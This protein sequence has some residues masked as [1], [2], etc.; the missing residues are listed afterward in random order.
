MKSI[1]IV[2]G[3]CLV[4]FAC[5]PGSVDGVLGDSSLEARDG[6][7]RDKAAADDEGGAEP[8]VE[9][10]WTIL[11]YLAADN[12][13][14]SGAEFTLSELEAATAGVER[15]GSIVALVDRF[16]VE[17]TEVLEIRG[18]ERRLIA[19]FDEQDTSDP[20]VLEE[21]VASAMQAYPNQR[22][23]LVI[24]SEGFGWRGIGRDN[25]QAEGAA[26]GLMTYE[27]IATALAG[28]QI[29]LLVL[30]GN[31][32]AM[33]EAAYELRDAAGFLVATQTKIQPD[34]FPYRM[35]VEDLL[36][37]P[38]LASP[39]ALAIALV[40][41]HIEYYGEQGNGGDPAADTS[42]NFATMSA[43]DLSRIEAVVGAHAAFAEVTM[44]LFGD[45]Y[46][47]LPHARDRSMVGTYGSTT[48]ADYTSDIGAFM[49]SVQ[50]LLDERGVAYP[51]LDR[52]IETFWATYQQ[53]LIV[54]LHAEKYRWVPHGLSIWYPPSPNR[55]DTP[56]KEDAP[57]GS[58]MDYLDPGIGLDFVGDSIWP[59][60]LSAYFT[61]S[62][63]M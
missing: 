57:F 46:N 33:I 52:A 17:G 30:E 54:E 49:N 3:I 37:D 60:Y 24:K 21:F 25:T 20:S 34:G 12:D 31:N 47:L 43:F 16:S 14:E 10:V 61:A 36:R 4:Q 5:G 13:S 42:Q 8:V 44:G 48:D 56:E 41:N 27:G 63:S 7:R 39:P 26:D 58:D 11:L 19:Q 1:T 28:R 51:E 29:D 6:S 38:A 2:L 9:P 62:G 18:G 45:L 15:H 40:E 35:S 59:E 50:E 55:F 23:M 22:T 53:A 32:T